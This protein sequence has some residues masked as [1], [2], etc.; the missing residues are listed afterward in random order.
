MENSDVEFSLR[1]DIIHEQ[2]KK[3]L[4]WGLVRKVCN[5]YKMVVKE[6]EEE[7]MMKDCKEGT[8]KKI[9]RIFRSAL[10]ERSPVIKIK[11]N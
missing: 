11:I 8:W 10:C 1:S 4:K 5:I 6:Y 3:Y 9:K 7:E 2:K